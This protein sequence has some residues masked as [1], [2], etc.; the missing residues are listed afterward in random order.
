MVNFFTRLRHKET[1]ETKEDVSEDEGF[2]K[3]VGEGWS[4][5]ARKSVIRLTQRTA[6]QMH[7]LTLTTKI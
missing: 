6:Q 3:D 1:K 5:D 2:S 4:Y 7:T